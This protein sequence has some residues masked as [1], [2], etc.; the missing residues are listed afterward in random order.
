M[1]RKIVWMKIEGNL[2]IRTNQLTFYYEYHNI[3]MDEWHKK[4]LSNQGT[5]ELRSVI[6][7]ELKIDNKSILND[8]TNHITVAGATFLIN[9]GQQG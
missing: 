9:V 4:E 1:I 7:N 3:T 5:K 6:Q 2:F 8:F